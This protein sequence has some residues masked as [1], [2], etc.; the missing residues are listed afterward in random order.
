MRGGFIM[1]RNSHYV[2]KQTLKKFG[3]KLCLFN[4]RTGEYIENANVDKVFSE[5]GFY[6]EE[7]E[8]KLNRRIE[9]QFG[10]LFA[11]KLI[12]CENEIVLNRDELRLVKKF[13]LISVIRSYGNEEFLQKE[14]TFYDDA[15]EYALRNASM[16]GLNQEEIKNNPMPKPFDEKVVDGETPFDYWMRTLNVILDSDGTPQDILKHPDKTYPA[17]RWSEVI[18]NGYV[19]FWD[20]N[21]DKDEFIITDIGMTSENEKGGMEQ[22]F[23]ILKN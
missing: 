3:D 2:P 12:K 14:R 20:S 18:N 22:Q 15:Q 1:S 21:Y 7:V 4:V 5:R 13:L 17:Y 10:N 16:L 11:N 9:S 8:D 19:A 23:I 6:T